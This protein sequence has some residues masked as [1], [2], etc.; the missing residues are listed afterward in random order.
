MRYAV[1]AALWRRGLI[2]RATKLPCRIGIHDPRRSVRLSTLYVVCDRCD[3]VRRMP[4]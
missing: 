1:W 4:V 2:Q 3:T